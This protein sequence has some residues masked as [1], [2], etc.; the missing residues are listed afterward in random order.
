M[1][2]VPSCPSVLR[3][4]QVTSPVA[5][6]AQA[7]SKRAPS[8][9]AGPVSGTS[10]AFPIS[11]GAQERGGPVVPRP[12]SPDRLVPQHFTMPSSPR[13]QMCWKPA[14]IATALRTA[15]EVVVPMSIHSR[16]SP[17]DPGMPPRPP[18]VEPMPSSQ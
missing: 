13:T 9:V 4:Q 16:L 15:P 6:S 7:C 11:S 5:S 12:S 2:P 3:P 1:S 14:A 8:A 17:S 18:S 10:P